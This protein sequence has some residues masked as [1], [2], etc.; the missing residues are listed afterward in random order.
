MGSRVVRPLAFQFLVLGL[1]VLAGLAVLPRISTRVYANA[2]FHSECA[3]DPWG[4]P[5]VFRA[6]ERYGDHHWHSGVVFSTGP[7]GRDDR[8]YTP[9]L[10]CSAS[11]TLKRRRIDDI[12]IVRPDDF[13]LLGAMIVVGVARVAAACA[14]ALG[15]L[16]F[17]RRA[18]RSWPVAGVWVFLL[19][20]LVTRGVVLLIKFRHVG[21][22]LALISPAAL[23]V[24]V[25]VVA[26]CLGALSIVV[27]GAVVSAR[28]T[29]PRV[30]PTATASVESAEP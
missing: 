7:D 14:L 10:G 13:R 30:R 6:A 15:F 26:T 18:R 28:A 27:A 12:F 17:P 23:P 3:S 24:H 11:D 29:P 20:V 9:D 21:D 5:W 4:R 8:Y 2:L 1:L 22:F 19:G 25:V 16:S